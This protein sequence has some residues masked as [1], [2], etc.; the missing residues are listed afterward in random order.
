MRSLVLLRKHALPQ[1]ATRPTCNHALDRP[2]RVPLFSYSDTVNQWH[3]QDATELASA[4]ANKRT[5]STEL[6]SYFLDRIDKF[7]SEIRAFITVSAE[8][9]LTEAAAADELRAAGDE[10]TFLGVPT[11]IKDLS[12][13]ANVRTTLGSQL[14]SDNIPATDDFVVSVLRSAGF[15][16]LGKT[17]TPEFGL[18]SFTD[19]NVAGPTATPWD[20]TRN[21]GGSSGGAGAA[22]AAGL[23]PFAHASD[24][25]GSIR[26]PASCCGLFGL[27]PSRGRISTAP[28][29]TSWPGLTTQGVITKTVRD[30]AALA[31]ILFRPA[32]GDS[33]IAAPSTTAFAEQLD[34][35]RPLRIAAWAHTGEQTYPSSDESVAAWLF[36]VNAL[37][38]L[39]H[40]VTEIANPF[41][42]E[43]ES[44]F[45]VIWPSAVAALEL[46]GPDDHLRPTTKYWRSRGAEYSGVELTRALSFVEIYTRNVLASL[47]DFD[48]FVT[49]TLALPPQPHEWFTGPDDPAEI[50]RRESQ[51]TP[52]AAISNLAGQPAASVP[53]FATEP[54]DSRPALPIGTMLAGHPGDDLLVLQ[55]SAQ[56]EAAVGFTSLPTW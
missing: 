10:R 14:L 54:T 43:L 8:T 22:V 20:L 45:S 30:S 44:R 35:V 24:G 12:A 9:A 34:Q 17:N 56:L 53:L 50:H 26:I 32:P 5:T 6:V 28:A 3:T 39:G 4:L 15:V 11:A 19:N 38:D 7:D 25:G 51:F 47:A 52:F 18:T 33:R 55:L 29:G 27:K 42:T 41:G 2:I 37:H 48:V 31:D 46:P 40:E 13:T 23:V 16:S 1:P 36:T 49:P 21:S